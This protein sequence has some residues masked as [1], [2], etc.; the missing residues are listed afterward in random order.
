[1]KW[2]T[3]RRIL[4]GTMA[5]VMTVAACG[6]DGS[7]ASDTD[8]DPGVT[9]TGPSV[10][11]DDPDV[12]EITAEI[13]ESLEF[14]GGL[15]TPEEAHVV[16]FTD[17]SGEFRFADGTRVEVPGGA[18]PSLT[19]VEAVQVTLDFGQY[20]PEMVDGRAY[21]LS[22]D[23]DIELAE[24]IHLELATGGVVRQLRDGQWQ[25]VEGTRVPIEH[26]SEVPTV[27]VERQPPEVSVEDASPDGFSDADFL[28]TCIQFL[29]ATVFFDGEGALGIGV[30]LA[31][32]V[33]TRALI[34]RYEPTDVYVSTACVGDKI[35]AM[36][37]RD[38][39]DACA[40]E[41]RATDADEQQEQGDQTAPEEPASSSPAAEGTSVGFTG[42]LESLDS[43]V[44]VDWQATVS[45]GAGSGSGVIV[46]NGPCT[47]GVDGEPGGEV[48]E[49]DI[50]ATIEFD[51]SVTN[52]DGTLTVDASG[53]I[54]TGYSGENESCRDAFAQLLETLPPLIGGSVAAQSGPAAI[55]SFAGTLTIE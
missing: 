44:S 37:L 33:C 1:M 13:P 27:V 49:A 21:V 20:A 9:V 46:I 45:D 18:F 51:V 3:W 16:S 26:F 32:Q 36:A 50:T 25:T 42:E 11:G 24:P 31:F 35:D 30:Q 5:L 12:R 43:S 10:T 34:E 55:G 17:E 29:A 22:T 6:T 41:A 7:T 52:D 4:T 40:D 39:I 2:A 38:A 8:S 14:L 54:L 47:A 28:F 23:A 48:I 53:P 15:A 19:E